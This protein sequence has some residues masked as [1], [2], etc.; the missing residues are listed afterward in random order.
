M[1]PVMHAQ[2]VSVMSTTCKR[3][4][5]FLLTMPGLRLINSV[6]VEPLLV[7]ACMLLASTAH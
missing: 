2:G 5:M 6:H 3:K 4:V 1:L 7:A